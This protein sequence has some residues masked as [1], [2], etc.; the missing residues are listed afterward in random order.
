MKVILMV[1][2][3]PF[4]CEVLDLVR[5]HRVALEPSPGNGTEATACLIQA[6]CAGREPQPQSNCSWLLIQSHVFRLDDSE[7]ISRFSHPPIPPPEAMSR[8]EDVYVTWFHVLYIILLCKLW[9][10]FLA[11]ETRVVEGPLNDLYVPCKCLR[12]KQVGG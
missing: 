8:S 10:N 5:D 2:W 12:R 9:A 3:H 11:R 1:L 7:W 4:T 6:A